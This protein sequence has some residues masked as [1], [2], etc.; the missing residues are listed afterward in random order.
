MLTIESVRMAK[1][2]E[3]DA[4]YE[5]TPHAT[6]FHS[7]EWTELWDRATR[8]RLQSWPRLVTFVDGVRAV[9]P[10]SVGLGARGLVR[11][12]HSTVVGGY[13]GWL[14]EQP[15]S[16][17]HAE[18]LTHYLGHGFGRLDWRVNPYDEQALETRVVPRE[19]D[20]T[21]ALDLRPGFK[22]VHRRWS[23]GHRAAVSQ[24]AREGVTV[25]LANST[26]DWTNYYTVYQDSLARWKKRAT[27]RHPRAL[28]EEL[29][30]LTSPKVKLWVA[31]TC[32][33]FVAGAVCLYAK[34][35]VSYWHSAALDSQFPRRPVHLLLFEAIQDACSKGLDWFD[36]NPSGGN[37]GVDGFKRGFGAE[38]LPSPVV[39]VRPLWRRVA[40]SVAEAAQGLR[41]REPLG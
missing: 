27:S 14:S 24:A 29:G 3:W 31:E 19:Y 1:D 20:E 37:E 36:F 5:A 9:L 32:G 22:T 12:Y 26:D 30:K 25:R 7:R 2:A 33:I 38:G 6:Y 4:F 21:L 23:K 18:T 34:N 13:G 17:E 39:R 40:A 41:S 35:N 8:G 28:F 10:M 11:S 16:D 15:L